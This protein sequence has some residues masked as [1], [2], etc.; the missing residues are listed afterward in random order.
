[1]FHRREEDYPLEGTTWVYP[2]TGFWIS[3]TLGVLAVGYMG[4]II[5]RN[6]RD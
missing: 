6:A 1:M 5:G 4:Y 2:R 3:H